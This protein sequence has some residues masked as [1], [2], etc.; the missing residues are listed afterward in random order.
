MDIIVRT[1]QEREKVFSFGFK[2]KLH[3]SMYWFCIETRHI[4]EYGEI[5]YATLD[6]TFL[7]HP[8]YWLKKS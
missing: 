4:G 3:E 6:F 8:K 2:T 5:N 1:N 7:K